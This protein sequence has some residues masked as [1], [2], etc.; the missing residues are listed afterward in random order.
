MR[1]RKQQTQKKQYFV[2]KFFMIVTMVACL[3]T[4]GYFAMYRYY[5][6]ADFICGTWINGIYCAGKTIE[7]V[8]GE[9]L[10]DMQGV[11]L[12][13]RD[14]N[15]KEQILDEEALGKAAVTCSYRAGL[16]KISSGQQA[17][18]W[19]ADTF[20]SVHYEI[21]PEITV[22]KE[23]SDKA[24]NGLKCV[25]QA[26][27]TG[28][29]EV[30][31]QKSAEGYRLKDDKAYVLD[32]EKVR[33][34]VYEALL[35]QTEQLSLEEAGCY[36]TLPYTQEDRE[37]LALWDK[38]AAFQDCGI[39]YQFG[40]EQVPVDASVVCDWIAQDENREFLF[41]KEGGLMLKKDAIQE[42]IASLAAEYD[43]YGAVREF[44]T[45]R[46]DV[47]T[48]EGGTY[49]N[50]INQRAE[51]KYLTEAFQNKVRE[52]HEPVYERRAWAQGKDDI[53]DTYIEVDMGEQ[54]MYYYEKGTCLM[55]TPIVTGN[56]M[57]RHDTPAAVC[58]VYDKQ[59]NRVLR[60]PGYASRVKFWMPVK[61]GIG[62]HDASWRDEF[63]G[64]IYKTAGSHGCINTPREEME[65]L[66]E[67]VEVGTPV[68]MFY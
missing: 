51:V 38:I 53:G 26:A 67:R 25:M 46:G 52:V 34:A 35:N 21:R 41:D 29:P 5:E 66:F 43:T 61:G 11:T 15:G 54:T 55:K 16:L 37:T 65:T 19:I 17:T 48:I 28:I 7:E 47:V 30:A 60:G 1:N 20:H 62:I 4:G 18:N 27:R 6:N 63:G 36:D 42:Y 3:L 13:V 39:I 40:E 24:V 12:A 23:A 50:K 8:E 33:E 45:T 57:R 44:Q 58:F 10:A 49:G 56:M 31:V 14:R 9:L 64:D 68:V 22:S 2:L 32:I 59:K